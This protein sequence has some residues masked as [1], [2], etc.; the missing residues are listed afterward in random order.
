M[1]YHRTGDL[2]VESLPD[3]ADSDF[4]TRPS[5]EERRRKTEWYK[6]TNRRAGVYAV[7]NKESGRLLL[8]SSRNLHGPLNRHLMEL[9]IGSH[10]CAEL[11]ADWNSLGA[12]AFEFEVLAKLEVSL[13]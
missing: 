1:T 10:R 6:Q 3:P 12:E 5:L 2:P 9:K 8:G 4:P 11:Q 13:K 7:R